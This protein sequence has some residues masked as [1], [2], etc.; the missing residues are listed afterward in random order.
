MKKEERAAWDAKLPP[1][2]K[3]ML[4]AVAGGR[5]IP[6]AAAACGFTGAVGRETAA[7]LMAVGYLDERGQVVVIERADDVLKNPLANGDPVP[8]R[9]R[10][11]VFERDG[12]RCKACH[13]KDNLQA[14]HILPRA[15]GGQAV[16]SN[17]QT[18]C[19]DCN[20]TKGDAMPEDRR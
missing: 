4:L 19:A 11:A 6:Q 2:A 7:L 15:Y 1:D 14:D 17:L 5:T 9:L 3:L 13:S 12:Y 8:S 10:L 16:M 20:R 18:L